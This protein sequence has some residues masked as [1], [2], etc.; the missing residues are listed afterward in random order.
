ME[1]TEDILSKLRNSLPWG[2]AEKIKSRLL[3]QNG[4][5]LTE[6]SIRRHLTLKYANNS[7][8]KE[9]LLLADEYRQE[10]IANASKMVRR[11]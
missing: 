3:E 8:I 10:R 2:Y 4:T 9:A 11:R 6:N 7:T 5:R 1:Y